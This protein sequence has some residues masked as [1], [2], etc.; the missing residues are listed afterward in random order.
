MGPASSR[1]PIDHEIKLR[2]RGSEYIALRRL[3]EDDD[4][5]LSGYIRRVLLEHLAQVSA[6]EAESDRDAEGQEWAE[7]GSL[8][9]SPIRM[10]G[11]A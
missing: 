9:T 4:R 6:A 8:G 7:S 5:T 2:V 11:G 3:A 10:T 1:T